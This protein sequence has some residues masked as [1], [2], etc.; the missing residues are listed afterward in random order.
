MKAMHYG[1]GFRVIAS[2]SD[3]IKAGVGRDNA[4]D[5]EV[6]YERDLSHS[7]WS[8]HL[9]SLQSNLFEKVLGAADRHIEREFP[10]FKFRP[11]RIARAS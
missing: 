1:E 6:Y 10:N 11:L 7:G 3:L 5:V 4:C 8:A 2:A 9:E